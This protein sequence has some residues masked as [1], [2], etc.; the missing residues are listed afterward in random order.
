MKG[1]SV[2]EVMMS[3]HCIAT[4][5]LLE[6]VRYHNLDSHRIVDGQSFRAVHRLANT[7]CMAISKVTAGSAT[8]EQVGLRAYACPSSAE[9]QMILAE[10]KA[11]L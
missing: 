10:R 1:V 7:C 8:L 2:A 3:G 4:W 5:S 11:P 9:D 6:A